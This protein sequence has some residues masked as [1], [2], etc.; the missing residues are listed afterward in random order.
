MTR[1]YHMTAF[2]DAGVLVYGGFW[3]T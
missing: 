2:C 3:G 1:H